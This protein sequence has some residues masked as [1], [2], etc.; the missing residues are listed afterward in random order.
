MSG[1]HLCSC[2]TRQRPSVKTFGKGQMGSAL[3]GSLQI[4]WFL[5]G[6]FWS[7]PLTYFCLPKSARAYRFPNPS[8]LITFAAAPF[9]VDPISPQPNG[10]RS[11][12]ERRNRDRYD[13]S[14]D[15]SGKGGVRIVSVSLSLYIYI[16]I[17]IHIYHVVL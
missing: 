8:K 6:T 13:D 12:G 14:C 17:Y 2:R 4:P 16:Y 7:L 15:L 11:L 9:S 3:M 1:A 10:A 5:T